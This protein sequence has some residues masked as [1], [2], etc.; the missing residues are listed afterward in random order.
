VPECV[1][2]NCRDRLA[3]E[4]PAVHLADV[5]LMLE[6]HEH[7]CISVSRETIEYTHANKGWA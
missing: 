6:R 7:L 3:R 2:I 1:S 4:I 5:V